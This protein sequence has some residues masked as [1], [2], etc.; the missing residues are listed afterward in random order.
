VDW[1]GAEETV[2]LARAAA[3]GRLEAEPRLL[4]GSAAITWGWAEGPQG[5]L[6]PP[7]YRIAGSMD[8]IACQLSLRFSGT[9]LLHGS[10]TR[11]QLHCG[12]CERLQFGWERNA[13][14]ADPQAVLAPALASFRQPF[15]LAMDS[16][17]QD[18]LAIVDAA[19]PVTGALVGSCGLRPRA[20]GLGLQWFVKLSLEPVSVVLNLHD[21]LLG[22][23]E[24]VRPL[25]PAMNLVDWSLG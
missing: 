7:F 10:S 20:D 25:L 8:L 17:A 5:M 4:C 15:V 19:A 16:L 23:Q 6:S 18:E 12:A 24:L 3:D 13:D 1:F 11:L 14:D 2:T 9:L 21:P 22:E